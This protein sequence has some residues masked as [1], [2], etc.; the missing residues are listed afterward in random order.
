MHYSPANDVYIFSTVRDMMSVSSSAA[1]AEFEEKRT[2]I[3]A[4]IYTYFSLLQQPVSKAAYIQ[5]QD[6]TTK[7][8]SQQ[9]HI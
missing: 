2:R 1:C 7:M 4:N 5:A 6:P 8:C 9:L 3:H